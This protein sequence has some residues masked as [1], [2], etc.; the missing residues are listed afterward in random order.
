MALFVPQAILGAEDP[1]WPSDID[2]KD[3]PAKGPAGRADDELDHWRLHALPTPPGDRKSRL[4]GAAPEI[5][6][7]TGEAPPLVLLAHVACVWRCAQNTRSSCA[8]MMSIVIGLT[9]WPLKPADQ[10]FIT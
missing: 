3:H 6:H 10:V 5:R 4:A 2:G 7:R 9:R 1:K 8:L